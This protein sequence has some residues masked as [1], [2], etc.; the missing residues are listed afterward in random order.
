[1][2]QG[3]PCPRP[4]TCPR[5][6][7]LPILCSAAFFRETWAA[8]PHWGGSAAV[9]AFSENLP[10]AKSF[11]FHLG[12]PARLA[13]ARGPRSDVA[14]LRFREEGRG[15][16]LGKGRVCGKM[17]PVGLCKPSKEEGVPCRGNAECWELWMLLHTSFPHLSWA[18][19][20]SKATSTSSA[21]STQRPRPFPGCLA[22]FWVETTKAG[23]RQPF[24]HRAL[25][26]FVC[27][28]H[29]G[30]CVRERW[31]RRGNC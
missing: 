2:L 11:S 26:N 16:V 25:L 6:G 5:P 20:T 4:R 29:R 12:R 19:T 31:H 9:S 17:V 22:P 23:H 3:W 10:E 1:M 30:R 24:G 28:G 21:P 7:T 15:S 27:L 8:S 14:C 13:A 18:R